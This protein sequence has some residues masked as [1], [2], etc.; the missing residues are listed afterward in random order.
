MSAIV[1]RVSQRSVGAFRMIRLP[2]CAA[3]A[4]SGVISGALLIPVTGLLADAPRVDD[5]GTIHASAF[6][7]PES[8][9]LSQET[10]AAL[11]RSRRH[12]AETAGNSCPL[13]SDV[14]K[15]DIPAARK[16]EAEAAYKTPG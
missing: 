2:R 3:L 6:Q 16:C 13:A 10:R 12:G 9:F 4:M 15:A 7:M 14:S 5:D 11:K 1:R 8:S